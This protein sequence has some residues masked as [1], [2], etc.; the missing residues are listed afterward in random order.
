M[1]SKILSFQQNP[2]FFDRDVKLLSQILPLFDRPSIH[3]GTSN[4]PITPLLLIILND[5]IKCHPLGLNC[6]PSLASLL[7]NRFSPAAMIRKVFCL[8]GSILQSLSI[9]LSISS[10]LPPPYEAL[11]S[12]HKWM[13]HQVHLNPYSNW[14]HCKDHIK[15]YSSYVHLFCC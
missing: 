13:H 8:L 2:I 7:F 11:P 5:E 10:F 6:L 1:W 15:Y 9:Y 12:M 3:R 4:E 14:I